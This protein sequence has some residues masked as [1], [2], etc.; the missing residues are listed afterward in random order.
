MNSARADQIAEGGGAALA[1]SNM[2]RALGD[3]IAGL[4]VE[5]VPA[6]V[7]DR[8]ALSIIDLVAGSIPGVQ[9]PSA[10][11]MLS[12]ARV[13]FGGGSAPVWFTPERLTP[14]GAQLVNSTSAF[15]LDLDDGHRGASGHC[16]SAVIPAVLTY[17]VD[18]AIDGRRLLAAVAIGY[19]LAI[20]ISMARRAEK[21]TNRT[22]GRWAGY[23]TAAAI[24]WL[25]G[26]SGEEMAE[27]IA[28]CG[29]E[30]PYNL[31]DAA[32]KTF[33]M[34]K[35]SIPWSGL[36]GTVAVERARA[37][38]NGPL[39]LLDRP[40]IYVAERFLDGLGRDW[41]IMGTYLKP[42]GCCRYCQAAIDAVA[43]LTKGRPLSA[44]EAKGVSFTVEAFP[45]ALRLP[46]ELR[47]SNLELAQ[48]SLP[49]CVAL[50]ALRGTAAFLPIVDESLHDEEVLALATRVK[51]V[52]SE[53]FKDAFP[54]LTP[55]RVIMH[56]RGGD[57][58]ETVLHPF[59]DV[60]N[61]MGRSDVEKKL[62]DLAEGRL[63]SADVE[64]I[65]AG[66]DALSAGGSPA[67]LLE[68]LTRPLAIR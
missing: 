65:I 15:C 10:H 23:G 57:A 17:A 48:F 61:P 13:L 56:G 52:L 47:P 68:V 1:P 44:E 7:L 66:V 12:A 33:S 30:L 8:A 34:V 49:F 19:E 39:E 16:G 38:G 42:Y 54:K 41:K 20:R 26:L 24:G 62:R 37:G 5:D 22:S 45:A 59:G 50:A 32:R 27:A 46:N 29:V 58:A 4:K 18:H 40:D 36:A 3:F 28:I 14:G 51:L 11:S 6:E 53:E 63:R 35:G 31:P 64:A 67:G 25:R 21:I 2:T 60:D 9:T 43:A 55:A